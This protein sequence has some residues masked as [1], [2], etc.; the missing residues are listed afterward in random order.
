MG[1][2]FSFY[3]GIIR[4]SCDGSAVNRVDKLGVV[5]CDFEVPETE[6]CKYIRAI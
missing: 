3:I 2:G 1:K 4:P 5:F 6:L